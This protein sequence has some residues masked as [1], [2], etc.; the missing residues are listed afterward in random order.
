ML[1]S[2]AKRKIVLNVRDPQHLTTVIPTAKTFEYKGRELV[3]VPHDLHN[4]RVL[5]GMGIEAPSPIKYHYKWSGQNTPFHAQ[6]ETTEFLTFHDHAFVLNDMGTGKTLSVLWA[7]DYLRQLGLARKMLVVSPLSTL[8]RTWADEV[9]RH[10]PHLTV[11]VLYGSKSRREKM[12]AQEADIYLINHDG[13]KVMEKELVARTD[14]TTIVVDEIASFRNA[15]TSRWKSL[16]KVVANRKYL[17][18]LTGTPTPNAPTDA[19]AQC[20][21]VSP[22]NVPPYFGKF[23]DAVMKQITQFKWAP[24]DT[25]TEVVAN[26]MQPSIRFTRD[27]CVDLPPCIYQARDVPLSKEQGAAYKDM[28]SKL[29]FEMNNNEVLAV[30]EAVKLSKLLQICCGAAYDAK[31]NPVTLDISARIQEVVDVIEQADS[32]TLVFVPFTAALEQVAAELRKHWKVGVIHGGTPKSQRDDIFHEF[33]QGDQMK[34]IVAAA[35]TM[36]HGITLT[37]ANTVVWFGPPHSPETYQQANARVTRPGQRHT[38]FIVHI[39]GTPVER[40]V[41]D[42][43]KQKQQLQ[44]LLLEIISDEGGS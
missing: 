25:A 27:E 44:G 16:R 33:Q 40:K 17:W 20:R 32:K 30:N 36:A 12:L 3:A 13:V 10:F 19:W 42:K 7:F 28:L 37:A 18:G 21:L 6:L 39:E 2:K 4:T 34:V 1:I 9:F 41:F 8:E 38:Q 26:A 24:R 35:Q 43:L 23:R 14:I 5:R 15:A 11:S 22:D 29:K 31:G